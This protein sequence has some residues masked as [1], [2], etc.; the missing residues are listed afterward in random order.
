MFIFLPS[1]KVLGDFLK[2][3]G[4]KGLCPLNI[5]INLNTEISKCNSFGSSIIVTSNK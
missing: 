2:K 3:I 1:M 4:L 5:F